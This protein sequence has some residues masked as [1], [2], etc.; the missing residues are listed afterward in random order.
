ML[1]Q[2]LIIILAKIFENDYG[3]YKMKMFVLF[4]IRND[5]IVNSTELGPSI[6]SETIIILNSSKFLIIVCN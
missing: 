2:T 1:V 5:I 3:L 6:F 4:R